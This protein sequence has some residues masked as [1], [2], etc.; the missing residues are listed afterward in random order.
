MEPTGG[1]EE[2]VNKFTSSKTGEKIYLDLA[3]ENVVTVR[4]LCKRGSVPLAGLWIHVLQHANNFP[5]GS[6]PYKHLYRA[7]K[8]YELELRVDGIYIRVNTETGHLTLQGPHVIDWLVSRFPDVLRGYCL[9]PDDN[10]RAMREVY[11][12]EQTEALQKER[13]WIY[14]HYLEQW[15][16]KALE[17]AALVMK[18]GRKHSEIVYQPIHPD[19]FLQDS[20]V[21]SFNPFADLL[22]ADDTRDQLERLRTGQIVSGCVLYRLWRSTLDLWLSDP[23]ATLF[24]ATPRL[25]VDRLTEICSLFLSHKLDARIDTIC[26]PLRYAAHAR[27]M[28]AGSGFADVRAAAIKRFPPRDQ[29]VIEYKIYGSVVFPVT[30]FS[31]SFIAMVREGTAHILQTNTTFD[32]E[33]FL[34]STQATVTYVET[35]ESDFHRVYLDP[36]LC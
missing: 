31:S 4:P 17:K 5:V 28:A 27:N 22:S 24:L 23:R 13:D 12:Q 10:V 16:L 32:R 1:F 20:D 29:V 15:P 36:L 9:P 6:Y 25:D 8:K 14:K 7:G 26:V 11:T 35:D 19:T 21:E 30:E 34:T 3:T 18:A 2:T 33:S